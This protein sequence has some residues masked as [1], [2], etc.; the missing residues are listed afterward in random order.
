MPTLSG[1]THARRDVPR[2]ASNDTAVFINKKHKYNYR[3]IFMYA[4]T[5]LQ[6]FD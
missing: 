4:K 5:T 3:F 2:V 6:S 1:N